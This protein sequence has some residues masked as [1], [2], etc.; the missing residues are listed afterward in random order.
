MNREPLPKQPERVRDVADLVAARQ[1]LKSFFENPLPDPNKAGAAKILPQIDAAIERLSPGTMKE[2]RLADA[3]YSAAKT[4]E[5]LDRRIATSELRAAGEHSGLNLGNKLRQNATN[6]LL[7]NKESRGLSNADR[8]ALD[9]LVR[10]TTFQNL[11]RFGSNLLGGGGGLA[12]MLL[13]FGV[14]GG[15]GY[16]SGH[17]ELAGL[18]VVGLGL[19]MMSNRSIANQA[20]NI[21][22]QI[23]AR[24]PYAKELGIPGP[25]QRLSALDAALLSSIYS[26]P[27]SRGILSGQE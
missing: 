20:K 13:G 7:S 17:P 1:N 27:A 14:G 23:R 8:A 4:A 21:S 6:M 22:A 10:G 5:R 2:L 25:S 16:V 24:S 12:S 19:R 9:S 15:A 3:N 26:L 18:P 11:T